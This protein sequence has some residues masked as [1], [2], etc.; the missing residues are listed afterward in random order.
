MKVARDVLSKNNQPVIVKEEGTSVVVLNK[1]LPGGAQITAADLST[2]KMAGD[3]SMDNVI[4]KTSDVE[5]R[6]LATNGIKDSPL[7]ST[8]LA[9]KGAQSGLSAVIPEGMRAITIEINEFTG[10]AGYL[11]S[12]CRVDLVATVT[13]DGEMV[14]RTVA[15]NIK[16]QTVGMR[17][18]PEADP[19]TPPSIRSVTLLA[20]PKEVE[21]IELAASLGRTRLVLRSTN[22]NEKPL[23]QGI[24]V[25]ELKGKTA[26]AFVPTPSTDP[27]AQLKPAV[28]P[29]NPPTTQQTASLPPFQPSRPQKQITLI[30]NGKVEVIFMDLPEAPAVAEPRRTPVVQVEQQ[31]AS[32]GVDFESFENEQFDNDQFESND[33]ITNADAD[34]FSVNNNESGEDFATSDEQADSVADAD[35]D[36]A[37]EFGNVA[38]A[39]TDELAQLN[40][41]EQANESADEVAGAED[42]AT[43]ELGAVDADAAEGVTNA[44]AGEVTSAADNFNK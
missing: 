32:T 16:V 4:T 21:T 23:S 3:I 35:A 2:R 33:A 31:E 40:Q 37:F 44:D 39:E 10:V 20:T 19:N 15:Q 26:D 17:R 43:D 41:A 7:L 12:G 36:N 42:E 6:V 29:A 5:G 25:A 27:F 13:A 34:E 8:M 1:D 24:T 38:D 9:P 30:R 18:A 22:D 11:Q 28:A 14:S